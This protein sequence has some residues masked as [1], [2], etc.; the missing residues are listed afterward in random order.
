MLELVTEDIA[1]QAYIF[2]PV[3]TGKL[4]S[5]LYPSYK[6][7]K[8]KGGQIRRGRVSIGKGLDYAAKIEYGSGAGF[9]VGVGA[10]KARYFPETP[11]SVQWFKSAKESRKHRT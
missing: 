4:R 6:D 10:I 1:R 8:V 2:T 5:T 3:K 11:K 7:T 9:D